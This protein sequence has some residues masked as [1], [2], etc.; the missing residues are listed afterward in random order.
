MHRDLK[1]ENCLLDEREHVKLIDF[2]LATSYL[3]GTLKTSCG[4]ADYAAP[5]L[6]TSSVYHGPPVDVWAMGVML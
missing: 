3:G 1:L 5:E 6:F 2:G 4:S